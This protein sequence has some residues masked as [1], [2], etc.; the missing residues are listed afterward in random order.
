MSTLTL[1]ASAITILVLLGGCT[2]S[3]RVRSI[4]A[5]KGADAAD[6]VLESSE[7]A[8]CEAATF[9]A[10]KRRYGDSSEKWSALNTLC[11][12][13]ALVARPTGNDP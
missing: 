12:K 8:I 6:D 4:V 5:D 3:D 2:T 7:W 1:S 11:G 9:G 10:I 13:A